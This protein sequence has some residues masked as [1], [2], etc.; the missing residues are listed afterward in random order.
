MTFCYGRDVTCPFTGLKKPSYDFGTLPL[1]KI[2]PSYGFGTLRREN[3][4]RV[5][6][7]PILVVYIFTL[8]IILTTKIG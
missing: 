7:S 2:G 6:I 8:V 1:G 5:F 4:E 3:T